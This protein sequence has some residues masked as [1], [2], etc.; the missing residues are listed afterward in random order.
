MKSKTRQTTRAVTELEGTVLAVVGTLGPCT[1]YV[2]R[3]EFQESPTTYWSGS[4]GAIYPLVLRLER[5]GLLRSKRQV[6]DGRGGR[7]FSLT[8]AGERVLKAWLSPPFASLTVSVPPDPFRTRLGFLAL[9]DPETQRLFVTEGLEQMRAL[10]PTVLA[11]TEYQ[12]TDGNRFE[13]LASLG[14]ARMMQSRIEWLREVAQELTR[15]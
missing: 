14:S 8:P 13:Y 3:R 4:A 15:G 7:L 11:H 6:S 1:P 12:R 9:L 5:R 2:I 10:L